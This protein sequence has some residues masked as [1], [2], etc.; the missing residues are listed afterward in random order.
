MTRLLL[1]EFAVLKSFH[2]A[3]DFP[4]F[5][6]FAKENQVESLWLRFGV[7][8]ATE[9]IQGTSGI[10]LEEKEHRF[11]HERVGEFKP[12]HV[13]F[14]H[15]PSNELVRGLLATNRN[16][17]FSYAEFATKGESQTESVDGHPLER[18]SG[19]LATFLALPASDTGSS[20]SS[21]RFSRPDYG[22]IP[23]NDAAR[24]MD[25]LPFVLAGEECTYNRPFASNP[26]Y[27][28]LDLSDCFRSGGCA[29]CYRPANQGARDRDSMVHLQLQLEAIA[30]T[31]PTFGR[32]L[33]IRLV[34]EPIIGNIRE[35]AGRIADLALPPCDLLLDSR[36]DTLV[37]VQPELQA[38]LERLKD[39]SHALH[40]ALMGIENFS[41]RVLSRLNKG[42]DAPTNIKALQVLFELE[43]AYPR[44]F[45]FREFG[46]LSLITYDP[47]TRP[48]ELDL[49]LSVIDLLGL[50]PLA[51]KLF[52]GRL[53]LYPG[54]PLEM[55]AR[56]EGL[57]VD[58]YED[59]LLNTARLTF[60]ENELPW[61]FQ[62][63]LMEPINRVLLRMDNDRI[64]K[65]FDP[66]TTQVKALE[67]T[68]R[69]SRLRL[70]NVG[71]QIIRS[72]LVPPP[73]ASTT[74][75]PA[76]S[77]E[78]SGIGD[79]PTPESLVETVARALTPEGPAAP[80][81]ERWTRFEESEIPLDEFRSG[82][83]PLSRVLEAKP[84]S[85]KEP[86][87]EDEVSN[88]MNDPRLPNT[89]SRIRRREGGD[90]W[91]VFFG[92]D[93]ANVRRVIE[94]T[95]IAEN[96]RTTEEQR[97]VAATEIGELL[98][99]PTCCA[100]A[101][102]REASGIRVSYF[103]LHVSRRLESP[104]PVP[105]ELN[106]V[107]EKIIEYVPCSLTCGA[108]LR[109]ARLNLDSVQW[110]MDGERQTFL[111]S[112]RNPYLL[113]YDVQSTAVELLPETEP[114]DRF[115]YSA[116]RAFGEGEDVAALLR[117]DELVLDSETLLVLRRGRPI[118]SLSGR[119]F[120]WWHQ[121]VFQQDFWKAMLDFRRAVPEEQLTPSGWDEEVRGSPMTPRMQT[122]DKLLVLFRDRKVSF[123]G[124]FLVE[125]TFDLHNRA[126]LRFVN[127]TGSGMLLTAEEVSPDQKTLHRVGPFG[128]SYP[129]SNPL[130]TDEQWD[131]AAVFAQGLLKTL[132]RLRKR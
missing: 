130:K 104:G 23:G 86:I 71:H 101:Y 16:L 8:A 100:G 56:K 102:A 43:K 82:G 65:D 87:P 95:D 33:R 80:E 77:S 28:D 17:R 118:L 40:M 125:W 76:D 10:A 50:G 41:S 19:D 31:C 55:K 113:L 36:S 20:P 15:R 106:P 21:P 94:L 2:R 93:P 34:G 127:D 11:L 48:E 69:R 107:P 89:Q 60:Y 39:T 121:Q 35:V 59:P 24:E 78:T 114:G 57:I 46:G 99:Y 90:V 37:R 53:R 54:L 131:G 1:I 13:V 18:L 14:S 132:Q 84:V 12:T 66:L 32:R 108:S 112:L 120:V 61:R 29:F 126:T 25:V 98:G 73:Q 117:G 22:W 124:F 42:I 27:Q 110:T 92:K 96:E 119:A 123:A 72:A 38:A 75:D 45:G 52:S 116:G 64:P 79:L 111:D 85:K 30:R 26:F 91:E 70:T 109:R 6:G 83:L 49:N 62:D 88:W 9:L 122:L 129:S 7:P 5:H 3:V 97:A 58:S 63:P 128:I 103:W 74:G 4:F 67:E 51:G 44:H 115:R 47:W 68:A 81:G 105:P